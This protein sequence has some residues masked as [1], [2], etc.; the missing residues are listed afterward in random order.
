M[1]IVGIEKQ[2]DGARNLIVFD[3]MFHDSPRVVDLI[4]KRFHLKNPGL[5]LKA[6]RR[7][8][9]YLR[10]FNELEILR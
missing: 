1:T 8:G 4:G 6:Y 9:K 5:L 7:G 10:K 2:I 3:P